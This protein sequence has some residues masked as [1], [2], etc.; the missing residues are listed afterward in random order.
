MGLLITSGNFFSDQGIEMLRWKN[1]RLVSP[2]GAFHR[3]LNI[4]TGLTETGTVSTFTV[5]STACGG[6][7]YTTGNVSGNT[8]GQLCDAIHSV[9]HNLRSIWQITVSSTTSCRYWLGYSNGTVANMVDSD[10][11]AFSYLG[12]RFSTNASDTNWK[13]VTDNGSG[14]PTVVDSG[15]AV[16]A[17]E[18]LMG[19]MQNTPA[20]TAQFFINRTGAGDPA[21]RANIT[22]K[23]PSSAT[24]MAQFAGIETLAAAAKNFT[25]HYMN[26]RSR[27]V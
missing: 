24:L 11:P 19:I 12:F 22:T 7:T 18:Y 2:T 14:T 10:T 16:A 20:G 1:Q 3:L 9:A 5:T 4:G 17:G 15:V 13:C 25:V 26:S 23:I 27:L 6:N 8:S 21:L